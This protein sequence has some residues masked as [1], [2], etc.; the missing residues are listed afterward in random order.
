MSLARGL[1]TVIYRFLPEPE[2]SNPP[3]V[4]I[5]GI[6]NLLSDEMTTFS[7]PEIPEADQVRGLDSL[8]V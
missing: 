6:G 5:V 1:Q 8:R 3:N 2:M 7:M 4:S